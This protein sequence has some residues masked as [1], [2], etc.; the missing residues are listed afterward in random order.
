MR[1][2]NIHHEG[3]GDYSNVIVPCPCI[4]D[5]TGLADPHCLFCGGDG[6][7]QYSICDLDFID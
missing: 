7:L 4:N 6:S 1:F 3:V 2:N 5:V